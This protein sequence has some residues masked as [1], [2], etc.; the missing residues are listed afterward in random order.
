MITSESWYTERMVAKGYPLMIIR[1]LVFLKVANV[2]DK[3]TCPCENAF[4]NWKCP[5]PMPSRSVFKTIR[6]M[7]YSIWS[8]A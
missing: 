2:C 1:I 8:K 4:N 7:F 3:S 5:Q 6:I